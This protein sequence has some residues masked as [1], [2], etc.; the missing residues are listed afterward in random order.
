MMKKGSLVTC[1]LACC[2]I[3]ATTSTP[4]AA[5]QSGAAAAPAASSPAAASSAAAG[6]GPE[7]TIRPEIGVLLEEAQR[8]LVE[9]RSK[10]AADK[11]AG[12][13][14]V[15]DKTP[16]E[17][18]LLARVKVALAVADGDAALAAEQ[19]Q[20]ASQGSWMKPADKVASLQVISG[21]YCNAKNYAKAIEWTARY[22]QAGGDDPGVNILLAQSYY[23]SAD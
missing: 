11:L 2:A 15:A 1:A 23:L 5:A 8:L 19:F 10:E 20:L 7:L 17:R 14:A 9:K 6:A 4:P 16:Y 3:L 22:H 13:E 12:A 18:Y 21:L